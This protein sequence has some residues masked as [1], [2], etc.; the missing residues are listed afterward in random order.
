MTVVITLQAAQDG[1]AIAAS[2]AQRLTGPAVVV[3]FDTVRR[4]WVAKPHDAETDERVASQ[5]L[6]LLT[7]G[8]VKA[9]YHVVVHGH[10]L[11][12]GDTRDDFLRLVRMV[13]GITALAV[14]AGVEVPVELALGLQESPEAVAEAVWEALP[15]HA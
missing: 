1:A 5:Q 12:S 4:D 8:Y 6:K 2:V 13:P 7:A 9:G 10:E 11:G 15:P 3:P 14:G